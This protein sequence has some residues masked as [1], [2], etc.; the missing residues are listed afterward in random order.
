MAHAPAPF[1]APFAGDL[2][3]RLSIMAAA[4][5]RKADMSDEPVYNAV[6]LIAPDGSTWKLTVSATGVLTTTAV[7]RP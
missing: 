1:I 7:P 4:M 2:D 3:Q 5:S 6:Q